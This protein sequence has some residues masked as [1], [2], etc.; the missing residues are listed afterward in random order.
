MSR[1]HRGGVR[2]VE[3]CRWTQE[4]PAIE[5]YKRP[6]TVVRSIDWK[7]ASKYLLVW[8]GKLKWAMGHSFPQETWYIRYAI[9]SRGLELDSP[10]MVGILAEP[11]R[12]VQK[13]IRAGASGLMAAAGCGS[14][15][16][17]DSLDRFG[18]GGG[19]FAERLDPGESGTAALG[20]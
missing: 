6:K 10:Y 1:L 20:L 14:W 19:R 3:A 11:V 13:M 12:S 5:G 15:D 7:R 17:G 18:K 4:P 8:W 16:A 2:A 9:E